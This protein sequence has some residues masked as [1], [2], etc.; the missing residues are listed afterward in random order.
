M[1]EE[2]MDTLVEMNYD[3]KNHIYSDLYYSLV[4][5]KV[6]TMSEGIEL[7]TQGYCVSIALNRKFALAL[8]KYH[9]DF[10]LL[11]GIAKVGTVSLDGVIAFN[12]GSEDLLQDMQVA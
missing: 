7:L 8:S 4:Y 5:T 12:K 10:D 9:E 6:L 1:N 3:M 2:G 11:Y